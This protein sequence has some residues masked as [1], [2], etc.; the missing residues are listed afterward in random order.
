M[1]LMKNLY[2]NSPVSLTESQIEKFDKYAD[3]LAIY[4][5]K[6]NITA[7]RDREEV[8]NKHFVDSLYGLKFISGKKILDVGSGGGFPIMPLKIADESLDITALDSNSKKC[9]FI[10]E[11]A[12]NLG[13]S[14][15][16]TLS[17]RAEDLSKKATYRES[18][19]CCSARAVAKLN[20]LCEYC[21]PFVKVGGSFISYK[22]FNPEEIEEGKSAIKTLGGEIE[23]IFRYGEDRCII[24]IKKV[25]STDKK[26]PRLNG[27]IRKKPL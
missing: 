23:E 7:I 8:I 1:F 16:K 17:D 5:E 18:F 9:W 6:F 26:Y 22:L 4:N 14:N 20:I 27:Q 19:D 10:E 3:L 15:V 24:V 2:L 11:V 12:K 13:L 21:M 25:S